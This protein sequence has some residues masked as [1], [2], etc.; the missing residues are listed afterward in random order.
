MDSGAPEQ[1]GPESGIKDETCTVSDL[2]T[3]YVQFSSN[4]NY[5]ESPR[6]HL[7]QSKL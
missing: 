6:R 1:G 2:K 5:D 3:S 4:V 7:L